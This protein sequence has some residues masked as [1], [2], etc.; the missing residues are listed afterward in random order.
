MVKDSENNSQKVKETIQKTKEAFIELCVEKKIDKISIKEL[1]AK[2]GINR[3]T[4]YAHFQDIYD[5]KNQ[6]LEEF[7]STMQEKIIP[8]IIEIANGANFT[9][10][11]YAVIDLY[12]Q[13]R[14][15]FRAFLV[16]NK[17][18]QLVNAF[19]AIAVEYLFQ[20]YRHMEKTPPVYLDYIL[21]YMIAGQLALLAKWVSEDSFIPVEELVVLVKSLNFDGPVHCLF[22]F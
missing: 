9:E 2:A 14:L 15:L 11:S 19:K 21:E 10:K 17:D 18:D 5:L 1:T 3:S 20:R 4:F 8:I 13:N 16:T 7:A 6:V 22:N 12:N